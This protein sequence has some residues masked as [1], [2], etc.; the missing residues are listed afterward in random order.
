MSRQKNARINAEV[1]RLMRSCKT[2][3]RADDLEA[4]V[5][6]AT[7]QAESLTDQFNDL[8]EQIGE[9]RRVP[10]MDQKYLMKLVNVAESALSA[11]HVEL[12]SMNYAVRDASTALYNKAY[13][14]DDS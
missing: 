1:R 14:T 9:F 11:L 7:D 5:D 13:K 10:K 6:K 3:E 2:W 4:E 8:R 12:E